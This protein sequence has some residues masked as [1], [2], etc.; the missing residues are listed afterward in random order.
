M[1]LQEIVYLDHAGTTTAVNGDSAEP[2]QDRAQ[3]PPECR[4][5]GEETGLEIKHCF[6]GDEPKTIPVRCVRGGDVD[7]LVD[8]RHRT[9]DFPAGYL[10]QSVRD[11]FYNHFKLGR[12]LLTQGGSS[13]PSFKICSLSLSKSA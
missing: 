7:C 2:F 8:I 13:S 10:K 1:P 12:I 3:R 6:A 4:V 9:D 11:P 5:L